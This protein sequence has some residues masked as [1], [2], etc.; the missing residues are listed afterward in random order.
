MVL[1]NVVAVLAITSGCFA[2]A[3]L[4][5]GRDGQL[6]AYQAVAGVALTLFVA[7][8]LRYFLLE[9]RREAGV[10][11]AILVDEAHRREFEARLARA[12]EMAEE[13]A[14]ALSV[15]SRAFSE[16]APTARVEVRLADSSQAHLV[17]AVESVP[18]GTALAGCSVST[19]KGCPAVR[20]GH[21]LRFDDSDRLDACPQLVGRSHGRCGAVCVP[22]SIMGATV[23]VLHAV[24]L[25]TEPIDDRTEAGLE[26]VAQQ[27]GGRVGL[28]VAMSQSQIQA[29]TDPLTGLL[30]RRS[31]ENE[32][33][34]LMRKGT[35]FSLVFADLD[36]FKQLN[37]THGHDMG[38]R[39]LRLF[40]RTLRRAMR[41][42]DLVA[43]YGGEEFVVVL[44][45]VDA[46][47]AVR[48]FDRARLEL[49]VALSDGRVPPFTVSAGV[50]D[51]N[52]SVPFDELI[53]LADAWLLRAKRNGRNQVM[54]A[55]PT[56]NVTVLSLASEL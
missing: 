40:A 44:P 45:D 4:W 33:R 7:V 17:T 37:D 43:R 23:G 31:L 16:L 6:L 21:A 49:E 5:T 35:T 47:G 2:L 20:N 19:P 9:Q 48:A 30:N 36:H 51:T 27:L 14:S 25:P 28:L 52:E 50:V 18:E 12:L 10:R 55:A 42:T 38:D 13:E 32:V 8:P 1:V 15:A 11:E 24:H 34:A 29:N 46:A 39:A 41:D 26:I 54:W 22:V 53:G 56:D 3:G